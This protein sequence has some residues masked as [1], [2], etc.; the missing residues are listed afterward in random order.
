MGID[1]K[2]SKIRSGARIQKLVQCH[3]ILGNIEA[4][5]H[6][7]EARS[8]GF[9]VHRAYSGVLVQCHRIIRIIEAPSHKSEARCL[10]FNVHREYSGMALPVP[11]LP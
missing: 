7:S 10:G 4:L 8:L 2:T 9:D 5:S 3:Q 6:K 1:L 11:V